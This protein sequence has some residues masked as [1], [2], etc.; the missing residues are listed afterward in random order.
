MPV[1]LAH[2]RGDARLCL[3]HPRTREQHVLEVELTALVLQL[4]VRTL[5][6]DDTIDAEPSDS[7]RASGGVGIDGAH[8]HLAPLD[9]GSDIPQCRS[10]EVEAD[11]VGRV[12]EQT[13]LVV[14]DGRGAVARHGGPEVVQL[15]QRCGVECAGGNSSDAER[16]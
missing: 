2:F 16:P 10:V 6:V 4:L 11:T 13:Y 12:R 3:Q 5:Q 7:F 15:G 1:L 14:G 9:P 8:R